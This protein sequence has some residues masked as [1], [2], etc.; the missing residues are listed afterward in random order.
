[1]YFEKK[2]RTLDVTDLVALSNHPQAVSGGFPYK[3]FVCRCSNCQFSAGGKCSLKTCCC[4]DE[5][6]LAHTCSFAEIMRYCFAGIGDAAFRYR[7]RLAIE[8]ATQ[9]H[10]CFLS[11]GHRKRFREGMTM[12]KKADNSAT[13][14]LYLLSAH[15]EL[16][17]E[18]RKVLEADGVVYSAMADEVSALDADAFELYLAA[19]VWEYGAV[20]AD[21]AN[22]SDEEAVSFDVFRV[23]S[24]AV[25]IGLYGMDAIK[26]SERRPGKQ[27]TRKRKEGKDRE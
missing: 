24:Y 25:P 8:R 18:T 16:W 5:R 2:K 26:I 10:S 14:Q 3:R 9:L 11:A 12:V 27:K 22:L 15:E 19:S 7:L 21:Y 17:Q 4:M 23:V 13:A 20:S 1:M 6:I